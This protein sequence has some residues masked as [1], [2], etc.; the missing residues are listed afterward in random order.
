MKGKREK[1]FRLLGLLTAVVFLSACADVPETKEEEGVSFAESQ[2]D[3]NIEEILDETEESSSAELGEYHLQRTLGESGVKIDAVV[4]NPDLSQIHPVKVKPDTAMP[5]KEKVKSVLFGS[6][7]EILDI[8]AESGEKFEG[9]QYEV[10]DSEGD[11]SL[12][13]GMSATNPLVLESADGSRSFSKGNDSSLY[14]SNNMTQREVKEYLNGTGSAPES[15]FTEEAAVK[16]LEQI[17]QDLG[18]EGIQVTGYDSYV[19]GIYDISFVPVVNGLPLK[20]SIQVDQDSIIDVSASA[21][22]SEAGIGELYINNG[23]WKVSEELP[24]ECMSVEKAADI[25]EQYIMSG[26]LGGAEGII[27]TQAELCWLPVTEDWK[28]AEL[29]PVWR[30][31]IPF[32]EQFDLFENTIFGDNVRLDVCINAVDGGLEWAL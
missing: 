13:V 2:A 8:T 1:A 15:E 16:K 5:D 19:E 27:Y 30:F 3:Q 14:F 9:G 29:I 4:Q 23:I 26:D 7:G 17:M 10:E 31:Y 6:E 32:E 12:N 18:F 25:L 24:G 20:E 22:I 21:S 28:S 11:V